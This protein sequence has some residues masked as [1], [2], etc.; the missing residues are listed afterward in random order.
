MIKKILE[1]FQSLPAIQ[2]AC[3]KIY[4]DFDKFIVLSP[5]SN[6]NVFPSSFTLL[7]LSTKCIYL[8]ALSL[9][10]CGALL[11]VGGS[12]R[13]TYTFYATSTNSNPISVPEL[14][15]PTNSTF[16]P[17]KFLGLL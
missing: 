6:I 7:N 16:L 5:T 15:K 8:N 10:Y 3:L 4:T 14:E 13:L 17:Y 1:I 12:L 2:V 9:N 11:G